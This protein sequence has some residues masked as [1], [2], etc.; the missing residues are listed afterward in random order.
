MHAAINGLRLAGQRLGVGRYIEYL[1]REWGTAALP[2]ER[3][4]VYT[5]DPLNDGDLLPSSSVEGRVLPSRLDGYA[6]ENAVLSR[7]ARGSDVLFGP[8]YRL[9]LAYR[10]PAVVAVHSVNEVQPGA[11]EWSYRF[12]HGAIARYSARHADRIIVPSTSTMHDVLTNYQVPEERM[13]VIPQGADYAFRP[14]DD[15]PLLRATRERYVGDPDRPYILW[16]GKLSRRRNIPML[17]AAFAELKKRHRLPHKLLL[18]GPDH[19]GLGV[20]R[21]AEDLGVS[22]SVVQTDGK[23]ADHRDLIPI[24]NAADLYVNASSYEGFSMT[25]VEALACGL[26]VVGVDRAAVGEIAQGCAL[27][28]KEPTVD[29]L[30]AAMEQALTDEPLRRD[31]REKSLER[32]RSYRW[33]RCARRTAE[34]LREVAGG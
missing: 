21:I 4:T 18:F 26:P 5:R 33:D 2:A 22:G 13:V 1:L 10:G 8:A 12:T 19:L 11:H 28:V 15:E 9:P 25:L 27:L 34:V 32:A 14:I 20:D 24:Y 31:L 7:H 29:G 23:L 16:V 30:A 6:W 17:V 3:F